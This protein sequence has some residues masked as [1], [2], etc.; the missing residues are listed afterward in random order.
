M[1]GIALM[2][3]AIVA[4]G[5]LV[6]STLPAAPSTVVARHQ[7]KSTWQPKPEQADTSRP[8]VPP[9]F[10]PSNDTTLTVERPGTA[11]SEL[12]YY[13]TM[14]RLI[15]HD[16]TT[17]AVIRGLL[18][19]YSATVIG[20]MPTAA[21]YLVQVPDP[22]PTYAATDSL[23]TRMQS[24]PGVALARKVR[25]RTDYP[26]PDDEQSAATWPVLTNQ[27]PLLDDSRMVRTGPDTFEVYRTDIELSF[28]AGVPDVA[29]RAFF[30]RHRMSVVGVTVGGKFFVRIP[31]P[32]PSF[33]NLTDT[34][35][36][37]GS[38]PEVFVV[39]LIP[40]FSQLRSRG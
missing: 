11:R 30:A 18:R 33:Q 36:V 40:R 13:R 22:G 8:P 14:V 16:T 6:G 35:Q 21:E 20:G 4:A 38:E 12:L 32:G 19:R 3:V 17:G 9:H 5:V 37:L 2:W 26:N 10:R 24:E 15:F 29:K 23:V 31:D 7:C 28:K 25:Y 1:V 27:L 34:L 39:S